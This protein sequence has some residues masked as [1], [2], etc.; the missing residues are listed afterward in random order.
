M[1]TRHPTELGYSRLSERTLPGRPCDPTM[2]PSAL[3]GAWSNADHAT[4]CLRGV[5]VDTRSGALSVNLDP[6]LGRPDEFPACPAEGFVDTADATAFAA[7][8]AE[9]AHGDLDLRLEGNL[10]AGLLVLCC[11][12]TWRDGSRPG[13]FSREYFSRQ[14]GPSPSADV[15]DRVAVADPLFHGVDPPN[16]L[17]AETLLGSWHNADRHA[18]GLR[19]LQLSPCD[20]GVAVAALAHGDIDWGRTTG[21][22]YADVVYGKVGSVAARARFDFGFV[23]TSMQIRQV[24]GVLVVASYARFDDREQRRPSFIREFFY[25]DGS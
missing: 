7:L 9:C 22:L 16:A 11:Y 25:R 19:A 6:V 21:E 17:T 23:E 14:G 3:I 1:T 13:C 12:K 8:T 4:L 24:G 5:R 18:L 2:D 20:R 10:N 15:D